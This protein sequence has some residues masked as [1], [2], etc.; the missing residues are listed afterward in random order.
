[1][2]NIYEWML[3]FE[4]FSLQSTITQK[5]DDPSKTNVDLLLEKVEL[6]DRKFITTFVF[7]L[8]KKKESDLWNQK[9]P[10]QFDSNTTP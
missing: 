8:I 9:S 6:S 2:C 3:K 5:L 10:K 4:N 7:L 1:M